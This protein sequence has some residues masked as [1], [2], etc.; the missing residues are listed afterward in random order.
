[1]YSRFSA[2]KAAKNVVGEKKAQTL[3]IYVVVDLDLGLSSP[4]FH[5][6][7]YSQ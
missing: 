3:A 1:L 6:W 4:V 5:H 7:H 2:K